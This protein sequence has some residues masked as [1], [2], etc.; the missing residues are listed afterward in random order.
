MPTAAALGGLSAAA[1]VALWSGTPRTSPAEAMGGVV[2]F[3]LGALML[4]RLWTARAE[5]ELA[6][7]RTRLGWLFATASVSMGLALAE[8]IARTTQPV[9]DPT[10]LPF[11]ERG[12][13]L[14]GAI[15]PVS[16][17]VAAIGTYLLYHAVLALRLVALQE[18]LAHVVVAALG[19]GILLAAHAATLRVITLARFPLHGGFVLFLLSAVWLSAWQPIR[20]PLLRRALGA[21]RHPGRDLDEAVNGLLRTLPGGGDADAV[22]GRI[23]RALH[24]TGRVSAIGVWVADPTTDGVRRL[25]ARG[26][27][28]TPAIVGLDAARRRLLTAPVDRDALPGASASALLDLV[29]A[30]L[31]LPLHDADTVI[32]WIALRT[33]VLI[34]GFTASERR[35]L[36]RV[37]DVAGRVLGNVGAVARAAEAQR[38]AALGAMA[39]GL[40]HEIR[41]PLAGLKGAAQLL[42]DAPLD[43]TGREMLDIILS[44]TDRLDA[45]VA[46][47]L[48]Y[49]RPLAS[50][51]S[52]T[53]MH[54]LVARALTLVRAAGLP[55]GLTLD[56][57]VPLDLPPAQLDADRILQVLLNLV[58]NAREAV[59]EHG[60]I[61]VRVRRA[62]DD[63]VLTVLDD[64]PGFQGDL[65]ERALTPFVTTRARGTGLGLPICER[66]ARAHGGRLTLRNRPEGGAAVRLDLPGVWRDARDQGSVS[67]SATNGSV[68]VT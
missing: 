29:D 59:G 67:T 9:V 11:L 47:F 38:L 1:H 10:A 6:S 28:D 12:L 43:A 30:D 61:T 2:A 45:V 19:A 42:Q 63:A 54:A 4:R 41:N 66:I 14:Q 15:P 39:A 26:P 5:V 50:A 52:T 44:E 3:G 57:D 13:T 62:G 46:A 20:Q 60:T 31:I 49:A 18:L 34:E 23:V 64:G 22:A 32:G 65:A 55:D 25:A 16:A 68:N 48:D 24:G 40:A 53:D 21:L 8:W 33:D 51:R 7:Q 17:V 58:G 56:A 35:R 36:E 37:A 27:S